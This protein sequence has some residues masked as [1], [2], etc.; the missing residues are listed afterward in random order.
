MKPVFFYGSLKDHGLLEIVLGRAVAA[1]DFVEAEVEGFVTC[2]MQDEAYPV[3]LPMPG[4]VSTGRVF[5]PRCDADVDRLSFYEEAEYDLVEIEARI[6]GDPLTARY[7]R[8]TEKRAPTSLIWDF[9]AWCLN[10]RAAARHGA[11][12]YMAYYGKLSLEEVDRRWNGIMTRAHQRARAEVEAAT[13]GRLRSAFGPEAVAHESTEVAYSD[14][15]L[16]EH[17]R[18]SHR[19]HDGSWS[20][21]LDRTAVL[22]GDA[23]TVL[24]YDAARDRVMLVEQ[25]RPGPAARGDRLPWCIE[26]IAGR[27]DPDETPEQAA[28]REAREE[29]GVTLGAIEAMPPFYPTPGLVAEKFYG[30]VGA[31]DLP[32]T[33]GIHGLAAEGEDIRT[34][35]LGL[36]EALAA[37]EAGEINTSAAQTSLMWLARHRARLRAA[38]CKPSCEPAPSG[39]HV[40]PRN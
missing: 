20:A 11:R 5:Y 15:I 24:P 23:A 26:V 34:L 19:R 12:E 38:W 14:F 31:A 40:A 1:A 37:L 22:W 8:G 6:G 32:G 16:V 10:D 39:L 25:F 30:F 4:A 35:I 33:G 18:L 9:E 28:R 17:H 36:D 2:R 27:I 3:L 7:F 13:P 21:P 29:G